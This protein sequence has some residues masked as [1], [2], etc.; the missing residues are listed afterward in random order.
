MNNTSSMINKTH[1][2][3]TCLKSTKNLQEQQQ[4]NSIAF[5]CSHKSLIVKHILRSTPISIQK[6][7]MEDESR[8]VRRVS[9]ISLKPHN[10]QNVLGVMFDFPLLNIGVPGVKITKTPKNMCLLPQGSMYDPGSCTPVA[11]GCACLFVQQVTCFLT[12]NHASP[13]NRSRANW[14]LNT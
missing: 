9:I 10:S 6:M 1:R 13:N 12:V 3:R 2:G 14:I 11:S 4:I 5:S 7:T 8:R